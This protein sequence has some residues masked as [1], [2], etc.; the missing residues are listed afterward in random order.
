MT[1]HSNNYLSRKNR[2][3]EEEEEEEK[4][5]EQEQ[6]TEEGNKREREGHHIKA[7]FPHWFKVFLRYVKMGS[8]THVFPRDIPQL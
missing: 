3:L 2:K 6:K 7:V 8:S 4:E 1:L 5:Q